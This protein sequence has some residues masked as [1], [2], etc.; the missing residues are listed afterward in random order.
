MHTQHANANLGASDMSMYLMKHPVHSGPDQ[1]ALKADGCK[2]QGLHAH[3]AEA[4]GQGR[5]PEQHE[6]KSQLQHHVAADRAPYLS[7]VEQVALT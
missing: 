4:C 3:P 7:A 5:S 6:T 1:G 2:S